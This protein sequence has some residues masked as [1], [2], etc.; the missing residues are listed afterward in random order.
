MSLLG[1]TKRIGAF[2]G[3]FAAASVIA[4]WESAAAYLLA[5][6]AIVGPE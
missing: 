4:I 2:I 6:V 5:L 1:G 3:P